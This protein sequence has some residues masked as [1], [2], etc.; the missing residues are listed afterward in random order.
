[1]KIEKLTKQDLPF[2]VEAMDRKRSARPRI[3][4]A[5]AGAA[6]TD[7]VSGDISIPKPLEV[8]VNGTM[9]A[10]DYKACSMVMGVCLNM[11]Q[12]SITDQAAKVG[13]PA[14][15]AL[16][17]MDAWVQAFV[18][19]PFPFF[20]FKD[21]QSDTYHKTEFSLNTDPDIVEKIV[22][23]KN[24]QGLKDA[25]LGALK[26]SGGDI[27]SYSG[28]E[29]DFKYF[30]VITGYNETEIAVRVIKFAL[31]MKQTDAKSLCVTYHQTS[32]DTDYDTY[33]FIAD[34]M[35]M[36]KM[37]AKMG[38][39]LADYFAEQ[40]LEFVKCFY[41]QEFRNYQDKIAKSLAEIFK[42]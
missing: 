23:I 1:M 31:H 38:D 37:Q 41:D 12:K 8:N 26:N 19:F 25:V 28:T 29:R 20:T 18:D 33:Q 24:V 16:K 11:V 2:L 7:K 10:E 39:K 40:L 27:A 30:G 13:V 14:D 15:E 3:F 6:S 22:N 5:N 21:T 4:A 9:S 34:K 35:L 36:I 17:K 42:K 32:L